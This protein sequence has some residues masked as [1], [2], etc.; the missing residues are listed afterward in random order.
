M[1]IQA[2]FNPKEWSLALPASILALGFL[3][4][5]CVWAAEKLGLARK[6]TNGYGKA[7]AEL[8]L[9]LTNSRHEELE[10]LEC[11]MRDRSHALANRTNEMGLRHDQKLS[12]LDTEVKLLKQLIL[13]QGDG[14]HGRRT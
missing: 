5:V 7:L 12:E 6:N 14:R 9:K 1:I 3:I 4:Y 2:P 11:E 8:E 10:A 13:E